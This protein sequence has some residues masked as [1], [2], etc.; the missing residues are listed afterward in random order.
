MSSA[1]QTPSTRQKPRVRQLRSCS[2]VSVSPPGSSGSLQAGRAGRH[3]VIL[4]SG[5][6]LVGHGAGKEEES[7]L[8]LASDKSTAPRAA[9]APGL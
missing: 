6:P 4:A 8:T 1:G 9:A 5:M 3:D 2:G 7:E